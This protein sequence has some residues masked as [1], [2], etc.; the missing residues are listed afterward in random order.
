MNT[1]PGVLDSLKALRLSMLVKSRLPYCT[2]NHFTAKNKYQICR[3]LLND[4]NES[5]IKVENSFFSL[6]KFQQQKYL[7][8]SPQLWSLSE[9][10]ILVLYL[11]AIEQRTF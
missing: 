3:E 2:K 9:I 8:D 5:I 4:S 1:N 6:K 10:I 7:K 11:I